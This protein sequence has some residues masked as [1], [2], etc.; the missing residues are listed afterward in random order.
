[1]VKGLDQ[2]CDK[3]CYSGISMVLVFQVKRNDKK[4]K[5]MEIEKFNG[6]KIELWKI[7]MEDML[8]DKDQWIM[9]DLGIGPIGTSNDD[10]KKLDQKVK[11][12]I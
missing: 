3:P 12:T 1:V 2:D 4:L 5:K 6:K 7:K 9:V 10:W 8:V 11:R